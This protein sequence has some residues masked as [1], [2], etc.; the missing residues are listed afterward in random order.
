MAPKNQLSELQVHTSHI[1]YTKSLK[2][3]FRGPESQILS[4]FS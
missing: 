1:I 3:V 2:L 4:K